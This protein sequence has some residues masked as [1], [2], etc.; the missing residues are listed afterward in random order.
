MKYRGVS[1]APPTPCEQ[2]EFG[3][4]VD[5]CVRI[6]ETSHTS[7]GALPFEPP[8]LYP[9][10]VRQQLFAQCNG[11]FSEGLLQF[12]DAAGHLRLQ[13]TL[14]CLSHQSVSIGLSGLPSGVF[15]VKITTPEGVF[16]E[17]IFLQRR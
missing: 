14:S 11:T 9:N 4:V 5:Y 12:F 6:E 8:I 2:F 15:L 16:W 13:T 1:G 3:Q 10:P 7:K 17:K